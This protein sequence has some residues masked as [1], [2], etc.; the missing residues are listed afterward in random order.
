MAASYAATGRLAA[1][2][3]DRHRRPDHYANA[4]R[5]R[6]YPA[7][8]VFKLEE[9]DRRLRLLR[10]G[11]RVLDLGA[12]PGSWA[13][14][15]AQRIGPQGRLLAV[16]LQ[17]LAVDLPPNAQALV[18]DALTLGDDAL[19][20]FAPYDVVLSDMA[21]RTSGTRIVDE[22]RSLELFVRAVAVADALAAPR[23]AF[24]GKLFMGGDFAEGR[25]ALAAAFGDV[26]ILRP[27]AVRSSSV[28][29]YLCG[30]RGAPHPTGP[31]ATNDGRATRSSRS[32]RRR[33]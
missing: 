8:S 22:A 20:T 11:A 23:A 16:D 17:P 19:A 24:V 26:K 3:G 6:G 21:P 27:P 31:A 25:A 4:A 1:M 10:P 9:I 14:Y 32:R 12:A 30:R 18:G 2:S 13:L 5:E 29:V 28:E 15:A 33:G 7:R